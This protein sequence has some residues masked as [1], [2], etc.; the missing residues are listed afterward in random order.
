MCLVCAHTILFLYEA[1]EGLRSLCF[2]P[3]VNRTPTRGEKLISSQNGM[4]FTRTNWGGQLEF[5]IALI[6]GVCL[7]TGGVFFSKQR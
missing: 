5:E 3:F 6:S 1:G 4:K 2:K 7:K